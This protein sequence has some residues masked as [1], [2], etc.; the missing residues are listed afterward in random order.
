[1][2]RIMLLLM[3]FF[4]IGINQ[5]RSQGFEKLPYSDGF[6]TWESG[7]PKGWT[8]I[9]GNSEW[10]A[11]DVDAPIRGYALYRTGKYAAYAPT[12]SVGAL[13][14]WLISP[15]I[16]IPATATGFEAALNF[17]YGAAKA[18][19]EAGKFE[20]L[21]STTTNTTESFQ[22]IKE[23]TVDPVRTG[24][25]M[26]GGAKY[27]YTGDTI[28]LASYAGQEIYVAIRATSDKDAAGILIDDFRISVS[29]E[30][31][32]EVSDLTIT[33]KGFDSISIAW[34]SENVGTHYL[35]LVRNNETVR[36]VETDG[37]T[38]AYTFT[39]LTQG[40]IYTIN[41][42]GG[43]VADTNVLSNNLSETG[44]TDCGT[45][46][47][48][49]GGSDYYWK[50]NFI[51]AEG[52]LCWK[53]ENKGGSATWKEYTAYNSPSTEYAYT[54]GGYQAA[55]DWVLSPAM[56]VPDNNVLILKMTVQSNGYY[57]PD[58]FSVWFI[59]E[60]AEYNTFETAGT[61]ILP[62]RSAWGTLAG[63]VTTV[64][65][66][67]LIID[68]NVHNL[69]GKEGRFAVRAETKGLYM[70]LILKEMRVQNL[71]ACRPPVVVN[72]TEIKTTS[73]K[74]SI[75]E[76]YSNG[77]TY[78]IK[79]VATTDLT[80]AESASGANVISGEFN[81]GDEYEMTGLTPGTNYYVY[82]CNSC[83]STEN[84]VWT[85][86]YF[87]T[88]IIINTFPYTEAFD[89][90]TNGSPNL[91][92]EFVK[93]EPGAVD[94]TRIDKNNDYGYWRGMYSEGNLKYEHIGFGTGTFGEDR[95][96]WLVSPKIELGSGIKEFEFEACANI[97][98]INLSVLISTDSTFPENNRG[99]LYENENFR[100]ASSGYVYKGFALN[101]GDYSGENVYI[102]F[103]AQAKK[104]VALSSLGVKNV[105]ISDI[106]N[107]LKLRPTD[108]K[109]ESVI[110]NKVTL[111]WTG[112]DTATHYK[113]A[114][115]QSLFSPRI[116][117]EG[118]FFKTTTEESVELALPYA[119][120]HFYV[121]AIYPNGESNW[122]GFVTASVG[123]SDLAVELPYIEMMN[124]WK[125]T[126][127]TPVGCWYYYDTTYI[128]DFPAKDEDGNPFHTN[129]QPNDVAS[130]ISN[131]LATPNKSGS[132]I[133][134]SPT[135]R[136][137]NS[138]G[139][140][141]PTKGAYLV[142]PKL[143]HPSEGIRVSYMA[144]PNSQATKTVYKILAN[145]QG[146]LPEHFANSFFE[147]K[148]SIMTNSWTP[149][150]VNIVSKNSLAE[151]TP[152]WVA[153]HIMENQ[154][155]GE[156]A[157]YGLRLD[158]IAFNPLYSTCES[159]SG[160]VIGEQDP[161]LN[162]SNLTVTAK[163]KSGAKVEVVYHTSTFTPELDP[164]NAMSIL[165]QEDGTTGTFSGVLHSMVSGTEYYLYVR[166]SCED[167]VNAWVGP[168]VIYGACATVKKYPYT[169]PFN[170]ATAGNPPSAQNCWK[171]FGS[172][173][174]F[175][176]F[177]RYSGG[178]QYF[179]VSGQG[180]GSTDLSLPGQT[181]RNEWLV[182]P[183]FYIGQSSTVSFTYMT[184]RR[185]HEKF[186]VRVSRTGTDPDDFT[187]V[188]GTVENYKGNSSTT[189]LA[190][191]FVANLDEFINLD[192]LS[193]IYIAIVHTTENTAEIEGTDGVRRASKL[194][195][196]SFKV[197]T[198]ICP[199]VSGVDY[200]INDDNEL[201]V[202][203]DN[204]PSTSWKVRYSS[205][206]FLPTATLADPVKEETVSSSTWTMTDKIALNKQVR[207]YIQPDCA[208]AV[209]YGPFF[210]ENTGK[211]IN[212]FPYL[213]DFENWQIAPVYNGG[214]TVIDGDRDEHVLMSTDGRKTTSL[215][216]NHFGR[217]NSKGVLYE[218]NEN[219]NKFVTK[220]NDW[221]ISPVFDFSVDGS[222]NERNMLLDF[223]SKIYSSFNEGLK[224][225]IL[226]GN[227]TNPD[228]MILID[229]VTWKSGNWVN[230][231]VSLN[232][233]IELYN[234]DKSSIYIG[235]HDMSTPG[236]LD[237]S[238]RSIVFDNFRLRDVGTCKEPEIVEMISVGETTAKIS[239]SDDA[240][241]GEDG[242]YKVMYAVG[243]FAPTEGGSGAK[244]IVADNFSNFTQ[245]MELDIEELLT[246]STYYFY[247][248]PSCGVA[249]DLWYGPYSFKTDCA[250]IVEM[251]YEEDFDWGLKGTADN[252][253]W[254]VVDV[255]KDGTT[256]HGS[257][258]GN[259][260]IYTY[261]SAP[262]D[263]LNDWLITP[264]IQL[265]SNP[266]IQFAYS[267]GN[268]DEV[269]DVLVGKRSE[270]RNPDNTF[271]L[272][273]FKLLETY[274][275]S[276]L[277]DK[278]TVSFTDVTGYENF[279]GTYVGD[280][281]YF[282]FHA[283]SGA[284]EEAGTRVMIN[285]FKISSSD[286]CVLNPRDLERDMVTADAI[287]V[288]WKAPQGQHSWVIDYQKKGSALVN[289]SEVTNATTYTL[290]GLDEKTTYTIWVKHVCIDGGGEEIYSP[291]SDPVIVTTT[292]ICPKPLNV[293]FS[294]IPTETT[295]DITLTA[296]DTFYVSWMR[297]GSETIL[298]STELISGEEYTISGLSMETEYD[299]K[300]KKAC[301]VGDI[302][303]I[304]DETTFPVATL[305]ECV[306]PNDLNE[307]DV[308]KTSVTLNWTGSGSS[309][310]VDYR[311]FDSTDWT[312]ATTT[313][314][315]YLLK[316]LTPGTTYEWRVRTICG[317]RKSEYSNSTFVT[318]PLILYP[319]T[320]NADSERGSVTK[321]P[322]QAEYTEG[323]MLTVEATAYTNYRFES[324][325]DDAADTVVSDLYKFSFI[326]NDTISYTANFIEICNAPTEM[327]VKDEIAY[328]DTTTLIWE[329]T[330][331]K[332][333]V[334]YWKRIDGEGAAVIDTV[335]TTSITLLGL[336]ANQTYEWKLRAICDE[337][338]SEPVRGNSFLVQRRAS[339]SDVN[340]ANVQVKITPNPVTDPRIVNVEV[341]G[342][343]GK[344]N[345]T[346]LDETGKIYNRGQERNASKFQINA[347]GLARG[348]YIVRLVGEGWETVNLIIVQ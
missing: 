59:P 148:D 118:I 284:G 287:T 311:V 214:W 212:T 152:V 242:T 171:T 263:T 237:G 221:M 8:V 300:V 174:G 322:N 184:E 342:V 306:T 245:R 191:E 324:W 247:I 46:E 159:V 239:W 124:D 290:T 265:P 144:A 84:S 108:F 100:T 42:H 348:T 187:E 169:D 234:L 131:Y 240:G 39:G 57:Q 285:G 77:S 286:S 283:K 213:E 41:I 74:I 230:K 228:E 272:E 132:G 83:G 316:G 226:I 11:G 341:E 50:S 101:L 33:D 80:D 88:P 87:R 330:A 235:L 210:A 328:D 299:I 255:N 264:A 201:T 56:T 168:Y 317:E 305:G 31:L 310:E 36:S 92:T 72:A 60:G 280:T 339:I 270:V 161:I 90:R 121:K 102:A 23:Y 21:V 65:N 2:K 206:Y 254:N 98:G 204:V 96:Q 227:S 85:R 219:L 262:A 147:Y 338:D 303:Y 105:K 253:C 202:T 167:M 200:A 70:G 331:S 277:T 122:V 320:L 189:G 177:N 229:S 217:D 288:S 10:K 16:K 326:V 104:N 95:D 135:C 17:W 30:N 224:Y 64:A 304:S 276:K 182:S 312:L 196:R 336:A 251:P 61:C 109:V 37:N 49:E 130:S 117:K 114:Y 35:S 160:I 73:A 63:G 45:V 188:I 116:E 266:E 48:P 6:E 209:W 34:D 301:I 236:S 315:I 43:A 93:D 110:G 133:S 294:A 337:E 15:K 7:T 323:T 256:W 343:T 296:A 302:V 62:T 309:Y 158:D 223:W 195:V 123:C 97:D 154:P 112:I 329:G 260:Y 208:G 162:S 313:N 220:F 125:L 340:K 248:Q 81:A 106:T 19:A 140:S 199:V 183:R 145:T 141:T 22:K 52:R 54:S 24:N 246:G 222:Q 271:N 51:G 76:K 332:Y 179:L 185:L 120:Y 325:T 297:K 345:W 307:T 197:D 3:L 205:N 175:V 252:R 269:F 115:A 103:R 142:S 291:Q 4:A 249:D 250:P 67:S 75:P 134:I 128:A 166:S 27:T 29:G 149:K 211:K 335:E 5:G 69:K 176:G 89:P 233:F 275:P 231:Q 94:W 170:L 38:K 129:L 257:S 99:I 194:F 138:G 127:S 268:N 190:G 153:F 274:E 150:T 180:N 156:G 136:I 333:E 53:I 18:G 107:D 279:D 12:S 181:E 241:I 186:E 151:G 139:Y 163:A 244:T 308:E 319:V 218:Q 91:P 86:V 55:D 164:D 198:N 298:G 26:W 9:K 25:P 32:P 137:P 293:N 258:S 40:R 143:S 225:G 172:T 155:S 216:G 344:I 289:T 203:W 157:Y 347:N 20:L 281:I 193:G 327:E 14:E 165:L 259:V 207:Y 79:Y 78:K 243:D 192:P 178:Y 28:P 111:T 238:S 66:D 261:D 58:R 267:T 321:T 113:V 47:N 13:N 292:A 278:A 295:I 318:D 82:V 146:P 44:S 215:G 173:D 119:D 346:L 71:P 314:T 334:I 282:A 273:A 126:G 68:L 232:K 1:M